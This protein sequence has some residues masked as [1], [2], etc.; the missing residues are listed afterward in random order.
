MIGKAL[1]RAPV[2]IAL[3]RGPFVRLVVWV[4]ALMV[5]LAVLTAAGGLTLT[6]LAAEWRSGLSGTATVL[7]A[8]RAGEPDTGLES[9]LQAV[10]TVLR[11]VPGVATAQA[12]TAEETA[13]LL[14]PWLGGGLDFATLPLPRLLSVRLEAAADPESVLATLRERLAGMEADL[15]VDD[16]RFWRDRVD[17]LLLLLRWAAWAAIGTVAG[18]AVLAVAFATRASLESNRAVIAALHLVGARDGYIIRQF[19][20]P[21]ARAAGRGGVAGTSVAAVA[22]VVLAWVALAP[23]QLGVFQTAAAVAAALAPLWRE[24]L[25]LVAVPALALAITVLA[26]SWMAARGLRAMSRDW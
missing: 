8:P 13:A 24:G 2:D 21:A 23:P 20:R 17:D 26:S 15:S 5:F 16:H 7:V 10:E 4:V 11:T 12:L 6:R 18:C 22:L 25:I 3:R 19:A 9:R 1:R 14:R